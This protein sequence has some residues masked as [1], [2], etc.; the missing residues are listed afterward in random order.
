MTKFVIAV[1]A[2]EQVVALDTKIDRWRQALLA[3]I[4]K[5]DEGRLR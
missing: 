5:R 2:A 1:L 4:A 3:N